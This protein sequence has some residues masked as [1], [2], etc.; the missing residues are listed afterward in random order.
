MD[1]TKSKAGLGE[2]YANDMKR[3]LME[4]NPNAF[5]ETAL[6]GPDAPIK[7]EIEDISRD[8]FNMLDTLSNF[9]YT[10]KVATIESQI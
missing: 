3:K 2:I 1:F 4:M 8:L 9:H 5:L 10:P 6:S 7:R